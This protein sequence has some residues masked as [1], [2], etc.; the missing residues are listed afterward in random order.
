MLSKNDLSPFEDRSRF[1]KSFSDLFTVNV[2]S[3]RI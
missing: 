2:D 1:S 3:T